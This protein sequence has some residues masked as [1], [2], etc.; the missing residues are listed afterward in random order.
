MGA[1]DLAALVVVGSEKR[2]IVDL[3]GSTFDV[4]KMIRAWIGSATQSHSIYGLLV[5]RIVKSGTIWG[6]VVSVRGRSS[7]LPDID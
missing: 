3:V 5:E 7:L 1:I 2:R 6:S 4:A